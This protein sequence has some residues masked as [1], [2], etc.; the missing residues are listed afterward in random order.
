MNTPAPSLRTPRIIA[1]LET[2]DRL[3][4]TDILTGCVITAAQGDDVVQFVAGH[5]RPTT[6]AGAQAL[7]ADTLFNVGSVTKS[8]TGAM[9]A[10]VISDGLV[11]L[12]DPIRRYIPRYVDGADTIRQ[13]AT[14]TA[15][16]AF[17][18]L[19]EWPNS[20]AEMTDFEAR[21]YARG[22]N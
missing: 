1:Q 19:E 6:M 10:Q 2:V 4:S 21:I 9:L 8:I 11:Q 12:D 15:G 5:D 20:P 16:Y 7:Q 18:Q 22:R 17:K 13:L 3:R 14:H